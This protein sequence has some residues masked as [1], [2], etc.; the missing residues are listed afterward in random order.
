[1]STL[2]KKKYMR[3][4]SLSLSRTVGEIGKNPFVDW[5]LV[6]AITVSFAI[7]L[8]LGG[9]Y[10][11]WQVT[12]GVIQAPSDPSLTASRKFDQKSLSGAIDR[13]EAKEAATAAAKRGYSGA[14][15]P[16]L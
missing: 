12:T 8:I 10:L 4:P 7:I 2:F 11:Y 6:L 15:D 5:I 13:M 14:P 9:V 1:M 16:S 3:V